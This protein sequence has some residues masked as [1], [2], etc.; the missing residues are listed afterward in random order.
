M[1]SGFNSNHYSLMYVV[2]FGSSGHHYSVIFQKENDWLCHKMS[3]KS[4]E[5]IIFISLKSVLSFLKTLTLTL[6][7]TPKTAYICFCVMSLLNSLI[8]ILFNFL[9]GIYFQ[10]FAEKL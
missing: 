7:L 2:S 6:T 5:I 1:F 4:D 10:G 3:G 8:P 9:G